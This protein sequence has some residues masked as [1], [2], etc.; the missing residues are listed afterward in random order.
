MPER[1]HDEIR[2]LPLFSDLSDESF[3]SLLQGA[4]VQNFPPQITLI[5]EGDT[6]DFLYI[7]VSG[8]VEMFSTWNG[9][10]T[11]MDTIRPVT[12]FIL[13]ATVKDAVYLMSARTVEK[14]RLILLPSENVRRIFETDATFAKC[15]VTEL[16]QGYRSIVKTSKELKLRTSLERLANYLLREQARGGGGAAEFDLPMEKRRLASYLGM[17]PENLSRAFKA[18]QPYGVEVAGSRITINDEADLRALAKPCALIDDAS[19]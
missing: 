3:I 15:I 14:S 19:T 13:A 5:D 12:T 8:A 6:S 2:R 1:Y 18:L 4:Y 9:R 7:L 11:S 16:A 17:A 10:E